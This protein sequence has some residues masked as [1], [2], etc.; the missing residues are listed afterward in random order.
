MKTDTAEEFAAARTRPTSVARGWILV[1]VALGTFMTY[2]D[3]NVVNVAIPSIQKSLGLTEAGIEWVV[4]AYILFFAGLLLAGGRLADV[5]GRR[6]LF[7]LGLVVFTGASM[8]AGMAGS[9]GVLVAARA[10]QGIGAAMLTPATLAIVTTSYPEPAEQ[11]RAIGIWG[12][13]GALA[14][15]VGPVIGGVLTQ[16]ASWH[17]IFFVNGPIGLLTLGLALVVVPADGTRSSRRLDV[18]GIVTSTAA[19]FGLTF[20]LIQG[21]HGGWTSPAIVGALALAATSAL[22]FV[23]IERRV[24]DPMVDLTLFSTR[25]FSSGVVVVMLWAFGLF[26]IYFFTAIYLQSVL[27]LSASVAGLAF[28]PMAVL[29]AVGA[30][31]SDRI[32]SR[33]GA[34]R[35]IGAAMLLMAAGIVTVG[36]FGANASFADLMVP[37]AIIGIGGGLTI[38]LTSVIVSGM[39]EERSGIASAVFNASREVA[40]LL[41]ITVIGVVLTSRQNTLLSLGQSPVSAF[42]SGYRLGIFVAGALVAAGGIV[43]FFTL[44]RPEPGSGTEAASEMPELVAA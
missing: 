10:L 28:V 34:H 24:T 11:A 39:P 36:F 6:R 23:V 31:V 13:V 12:A 42:L 19:L 26:G 38:P 15:A 5:F 33:V 41:G 35:L 37:F 21:P 30:T 3:N 25:S 22:A 2:L 32:V 43:A 9:A 8:M 40:G 17:W 4:S 20:A 44:P 27:G 18:A 7:L 1:A 16:H 29:M 14:L